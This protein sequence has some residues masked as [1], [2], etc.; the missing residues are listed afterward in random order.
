MN[1]S[2]SCFVLARE[3]LKNLVKCLANNNARMFKLIELFVIDDL[4]MYCLV[5]ERER[6]RERD[7]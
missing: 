1:D 7:V 5:R 4:I 6:E 3:S 2:K